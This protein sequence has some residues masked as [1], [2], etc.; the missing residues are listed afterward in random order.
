[1]PRI[2][3]TTLAFYLALICASCALSLAVFT[4]YRSISPEQAQSIEMAMSIF[5]DLGAAS[6]GAFGMGKHRDSST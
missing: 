5:R 1:M 3:D 4:T 2:S 6:M